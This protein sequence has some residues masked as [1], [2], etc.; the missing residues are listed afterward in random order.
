MRHVA[1]QSTAGN[2]LRDGLGW[3]D[4][5]RGKIDIVA[6]DEARPRT[7]SYPSDNAAP[8]SRSGSC[9]E[10][11]GPPL[12]TM[13]ARE[14]SGCWGE[15]SLRRGAELPAALRRYECQER[16]ILLQR[17]RRR[18][19]SGSYGIGGRGG[20]R[21]AHSRTRRIT[22]HHSAYACAGGRSISSLSA[23]STAMSPL[24]LARTKK[25]TA[26]MRAIEPPPIMIPPSV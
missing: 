22:H 2:A 11:N 20:K 6:I 5:S 19:E 1:T 8:A 14:A 24:R 9:R 23:S 26:R 17:R 25:I 3:C 15:A 4:P 16:G 13:Q 18:E 7:R 21:R 10:M 12:S